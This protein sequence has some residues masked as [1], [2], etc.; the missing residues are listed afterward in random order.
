M[1]YSFVIKRELEAGEG[2]DRFPPHSSSKGQA[3]ITRPSFGLGRRVSDP[4]RSN[5]DCHH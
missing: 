3:D 4:V 1:G 5:Q 2:K